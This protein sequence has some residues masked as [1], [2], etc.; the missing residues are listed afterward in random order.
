MDITMEVEGVL[1]RSSVKNGLLNVYS[2]HSTSGV[3]INE[4]ESGLVSDFQTAL[5]KIIP[6]VLVTSMIALITMPTAISG[7]SYWEAV[8]P[9]L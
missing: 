7:A 3:V 8:R 1:A 2:R 6:Q 4:N 5:E 9:S